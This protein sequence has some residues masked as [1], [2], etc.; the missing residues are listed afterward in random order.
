M[1][2]TISQNPYV[3]LFHL[4]INSVFIYLLPA[5]RNCNSYWITSL[6]ALSQCS[7]VW[8]VHHQPKTCIF[9][10]ADKMYKYYWTNYH[11]IFNYFR[12][13]WKFFLKKSTLLNRSCEKWEQLLKHKVLCTMRMWTFPPCDFCGVNNLCNREYEIIS[14]R[15]TVEVTINNYSSPFSYSNIL[16]HSNTIPKKENL[17]R[18]VASKMSIMVG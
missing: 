1:H 6:D 16:G 3:F 8:L 4:F 15:L 5:R 10:L 9:R 2:S 17:N 11:F 7:I 14:D 12:P 18:R 13:V